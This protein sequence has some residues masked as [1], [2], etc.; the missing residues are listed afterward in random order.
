MGKKKILAAT[1]TYDERLS[2]AGVDILE[3]YYGWDR[4]WT[5]L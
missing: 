5:E 3:D 4:N 2:A 1:R